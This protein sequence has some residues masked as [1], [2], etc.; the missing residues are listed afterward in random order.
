MAIP[1]II[2]QTGRSR[3]ISP[4]D[5]ACQKR[6]LTLHP[7]WEYRFY[8]DG[9]CR[10]MVKCY[11]PSFIPVYDSYP[12]NIERVDAF[13]II[14]V[15]AMGGFYVDLDVECFKNLDDLCEYHCVL[16][17]EKTLTIDETREFGL[18]DPVRVAN[19]M[20]GSE[21]RHPFFLDVLAEMVKRSERVIRTENDVLEATGPGLLTTVYFNCREKFRDVVLLPNR[22]LVCSN[23]DCGGVACHFGNYAKH[24][25]AG[26][27]RFER[28]ARGVDKAIE[29]KKPVT[30]EQLKGIFSVLQLEMGGVPTST[31]LYVLRTYE[32]ARHDGLSSVFHRTR[33]IGVVVDDTTGLA[34]QKVLVSGIPSV[35]VDKISP[36]N[37]NVVYTTFEGTRLR[38]SWV[39]AINKHFQYCIVPHRHVESVFK[40]SGVDIPIRVI[41]QGFTRHK[42]M[43][44]RIGVDEVFRVGFLGLPVKSKNLPK[45]LHACTNLQRRIP[46]IKLAVHVSRS[47]EWIDGSHVE[48]LKSFPFVEWSEGVMSE[49]EVAGWYNRLSCFI[50]PSSGEGWSFTPRESLYLRVPTVL[51]DIPVHDQLVESGYCKVISP[52]GLE[53]AKF[54]GRVFG[55]WHEIAVEDIE[56]AILDVYQRYGFFQIKAFEGSEWIEDR[57]ANESTSQQLLSFVE[58]I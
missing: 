32:E 45:L 26:G 54:E 39:E 40:D 24:H 58:S 44:R 29:K 7:N 14:A 5:E 37:T 9:D 23:P 16:G 8:D 47:C 1:K 2:H 33:R 53:D 18:R 57:W 50:C 17:E 51:T 49:D 13:R 22:D 12:E 52:K 10:A 38:V 41:H 43:P 15:W 11:L 55:Q 20:F 42:R 48:A 31:D 36:R 56:S 21:P 4:E 19:Y 28:G 35:Y 27:W 34:G 6:L 3:S 25:H 46:T 30:P